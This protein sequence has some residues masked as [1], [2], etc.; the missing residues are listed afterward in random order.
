M[1][2]LTILN[3]LITDDILIQWEDEDGEGLDCTYNLDGYPE[4]TIEAI[5]Q[6]PLPPKWVIEM[7]KSHVDNNHVV[8]TQ[9]S[10][11]DERDFEFLLG[12][13]KNRKLKSLIKGSIFTD[14]HEGHIFDY[15]EDFVGAVTDDAE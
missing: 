1:S 15:M 8:I 10:R 3:V 13:R 14:V 7:A 2:E 11:F 5:I 9:V 4:G 12:M 6:S